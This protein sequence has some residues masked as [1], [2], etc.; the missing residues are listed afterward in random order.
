MEFKIYLEEGMRPLT[1]AEWDKPNS[2]TN[3][4]R[5]NILKK[6]I[7]NKSDIVTIDNETI[8]LANDER[9]FGSIQDFEDSPGKAFTLYKTDGGTISSSKIA[10]SPVFGG[11]KGSGGGTENTAYVESQQCYWNAAVL[12]NKGQPIEFFTPEVLEKYKNK[13]SIGKTTFEDILE[14]VDA[15]WGVSA[16]LS[17]QILIKEGYINNKHTFH[18]DSSEMQYIYKAKDVAF[19]NSGLAK[20]KDDKWNPGDI[21][22][23]EK[24]LNLKAE[25]DIT[26]VSALNLSIKK[27][28]DERRLVPISLKKVAKK[29]KIITQIPAGAD[30][31]QFKFKKVLLQSNRGNFFSSKSATIHFDPNGTMDIRANAPLAASKFEIMSKKARAG[32]AGWTVF[33]DF[34]KRYMNENI[35]NYTFVK[36]QGILLAKGDKKAVSN[37]K[38]MATKVDRSAGNNFEA[39]VS[40]KDKIWLTAKYAAVHAAYAI[41]TN[42]GSK[43]NALI[44]GIV[45][46]AASTSEDACIHIV[47]KEG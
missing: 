17:A 25:L 5:I 24:G 14:K 15:S 23:I 11:G 1:P 47:V 21:W 36:S 32:G 10:K 33:M 30:S 29:A 3:E 42:K 20:L 37:F 44:N 43:A 7:R 12:K 31:P 27:L 35:P 40:K 19:K 4:P 38:K 16:Y 41:F 18:R 8:T 28:M 2:Q 26:S 9:N 39:E 45:N 34:A 13:V 6:L 46:Y 22:A